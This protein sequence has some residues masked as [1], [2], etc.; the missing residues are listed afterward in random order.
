MCVDGQ[1]LVTQVLP[2]AAGRAKDLGVISIASSGP[3]VLG[4]AIGALLVTSLG[5]YPTLYLSVAAIT[6]LGSA[7]IWKIRS[8]P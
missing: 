5:E 8:V 3:L 6:V 4:P 2:S 1:A 7:C